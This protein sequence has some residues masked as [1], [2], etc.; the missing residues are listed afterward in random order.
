M[1]ILKASDAEGI[2]RAPVPNRAVGRLNKRMEEE[3]GTIVG[4]W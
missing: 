2:F 1:I 4:N 3:R